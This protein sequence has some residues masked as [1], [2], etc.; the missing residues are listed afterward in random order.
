MKLLT[1]ALLLL[2]TSGCTSL[3]PVEVAP[4]ILREKIVSDNIV[5]VGDTVKVVT[6]DGVST[7]FKVAAISE[8]HI[9]GKVTWSSK[10]VDIPIRDIVALETREFSGGKTS[11]VVGGSL[12]WLYI[13]AWAI[14]PAMIVM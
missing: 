5:S 11:M 2:F 6:S 3:K 7:E 4:E 12:L 10:E 13:V 14:A 1:L 8:S 9:L